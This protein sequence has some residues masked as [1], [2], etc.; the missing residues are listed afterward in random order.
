[1]SRLRFRA[2]RLRCATTN[3]PF[4]ADLSFSDGLNVIEARNSRGKSISTQSILYALGME[5]ML[6]PRHDVPL[7]DAMTIR[8]RAP[9]DREFE[10]TESRVWLEVEGVAGRTAT[11][12]RWAKHATI[13]LKLVSVWD[14]P[15]LTLGGTY[16]QHDHLVRAEGVLDR[17]V[18]LH[19]FLCDLIGWSP[20]TILQAN[21]RERPLYLE[22]LFGLLFV[23]Q[24][25]GWAGIQALKPQYFQPEAD[26]RAVEYLTG[27]MVYERSRR[28]AEI[29]RDLR[30]LR[31]AWRTAIVRLQD[32]LSGSALLL[33]GVPS[34]A[35]QTFN[36]DEAQILHL[37]SGRSL[38]EE[39]GEVRERLMRASE[40]LSVPPAT[41]DQQ[42][43]AELAQLERDLP[44]LSAAT[45]GLQ[46][47][48][49]ITESTV[50]S[51]DQTIE[52]LREDLQ[53]NKDVSRIR[54][55]GSSGWA[56]S[57]PDCPTC[58]RP[59]GDVVLVSEQQRPMSLDDN[60]AFIDAET[61]TFLALRAATG[62]ELELR[63]EQLGAHTNKLRELRLRL[64]ALR[65]ATTSPEG[66]PS[67]AAIRD[68]LLLEDRLQR[69]M[70]FESQLGDLRDTLTAIAAN[71]RTLESARRGLPDEG[72]TPEERATLQQLRDDFVQQLE[73]YG[74]TSKSPEDLSLSDTSYRPMDRGA[75]VSIG[76]S[77]S[78][79]IRMIWAYLIAL[80]EV[81]RDPQ[82]H[83]PGFVVFDEPG[84]Q[85]TDRVSFDSLLARA[86]TAGEAGQ[87]VI[88][89]TSE[90]PDRLASALEGIPHSLR[91]IPGRLLLPLTDGT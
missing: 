5:A 64:R 82:S 38:L 43:L 69:L 23:E 42:Q 79:G 35:S 11:L 58:H 2:L 49:A 8:L 66:T 14:G 71:L 26:R 39:V 6:G 22:Y 18:G 85:S 4:G 72:L 62:D 90:E 31:D 53:R 28:R 88:V 17:D 32:R 13:D 74:F 51:V 41:D 33:N 80:M 48:V 60:I 16:H 78:D 52:R 81:G 21:G 55:M 68:Q 1:V 73:V 84:Q 75:E 47:R 36:S 15:A 37:E 24:R 65:S 3:G 40:T 12:M 30:V 89:A 61:K 7:P 63:R 29:D 10:V 77:A 9:D 91:T 86:S 83:H 45:A 54:S 34:D 56:Q 57:D 50:K 70:Y 67:A 19:H 44:I 87:Q 76:V 20:P 27:L 25:G 59:L 46:E